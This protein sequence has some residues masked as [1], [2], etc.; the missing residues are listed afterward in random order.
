MLVEHV[1]LTPPVGE[2]RGVAQLLRVVRSGSRE[3]LDDDGLLAEGGPP[4]PDGGGSRPTGQRMPVRL[5]LPHGGDV[6][7]RRAS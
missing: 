6:S 1:R 5:R 4:D 3:P 7:R 2:V